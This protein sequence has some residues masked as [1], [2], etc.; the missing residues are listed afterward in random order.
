M[1]ESDRR[2]RRRREA[3]PVRD[4]GPHRDPPDVVDVCEPV[5][6][7]TDAGPRQ[8]RPGRP[9]LG[10]LREK[11]VEAEAPRIGVLHVSDDDQVGAAAARAEGDRARPCRSVSAH[12]IPRRRERT[13]SRTTRTAS[14][15]PCAESRSSTRPSR[16]LVTRYQTVPPRIPQPGSASSPVAPSVDPRAV[17]GSF[18][19]AAPPRLSLAGA[20]KAVQRI[21]TLRPPFQAGARRR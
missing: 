14:R 15:S 6:G 7:G 12:P 13:R 20:G 1:D 4:A 8:A 11:R 2:A 17:P 9:A 3:D 16:R 18:S 5:H 10:R 21:R 19:G